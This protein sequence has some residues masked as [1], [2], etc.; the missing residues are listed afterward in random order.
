KVKL[1]RPVRSTESG[2][3][4]IMTAEE[5]KGLVVSW[6]LNPFPDRNTRMDDKAV[7]VFYN[8]NNEMFL[9]RNG[10]N[11]S[12]LTFTLTPLIYTA[13]H[14]LYCWIFFVSADGKRVSETE[15]LG[16]LKMPERMIP[17]PQQISSV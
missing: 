6:E 9:L 8:R 10:V 11:R 5:G 13:G 16:M 12:L 3:N 7:I 1:S 4:T 17:A 14:E 15:Y 2:W